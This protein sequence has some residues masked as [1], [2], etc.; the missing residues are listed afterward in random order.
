M[1]SFDSESQFGSALWSSQKSSYFLTQETTTKILNYNVNF[2]E[3]I[4]ILPDLNLIAKSLQSMNTNQSNVGRLNSVNELASSTGS[5]G[6]HNRIRKPACASDSEM[7]LTPKVVYPMNKFSQLNPIETITT[8]T[9][10]NSLTTTTTTT[11]TK[12]VITTPVK[13]KKSDSILLHDQI[14]PVLNSIF[15]LPV[16]QNVSRDIMNI[17]FQFSLRSILFESTLFVSVFEDV[18]FNLFNSA[19]CASKKLSIQE[20]NSIHKI[21]T[22]F[23]SK[24]NDNLKKNDMNSTNDFMSA[25]LPRSQAANR[26]SITS[27]EDLENINQY[28]MIEHVKKELKNTICL[29]L[30][31]IK[32][33]DSVNKQIIDNLN[34][35]SQSST[36][37]TSS[38][39]NNE[40]DSEAKNFQFYFKFNVAQSTSV[41]SEPSNFGMN[42]NG[43]EQEQPI[44]DSDNRFFVYGL[45]FLNNTVSGESSQASNRL[46]FF[47]FD[48]LF[49]NIKKS[50]INSSSNTYLIRKSL[51]SAQKI[52]NSSKNQNM[53]QTSTSESN[54]IAFSDTYRFYYRKGASDQLRSTN[55]SSSTTTNN[56]NTISTSNRKISNGEALNSRIYMNNNSAPVSTTPNTFRKKFFSIS[57]IL[58]FHLNNYTNYVSS[59]DSTFLYY[60]D[61]VEENCAK[62]YIE[63]V[64]HYLGIHSSSN[65]SVPRSTSLTE[66]KR[67]KFETDSIKKLLKIG[68]KLKLIDVDL[69]D[70]LKIICAHLSNHNN[71]E[72][73]DWSMTCN[74]SK[75]DSSGRQSYLEKKFNDLFLKKFNLL[76]GFNDLFIFTPN[77]YCKNMATSQD[78]QLSSIDHSFDNGNAPANHR[79]SRKRL[80][81][82]SKHKKAHKQAQSYSQVDSDNRALSAS[83]LGTLRNTARSSDSIKLLIEKELN[84]SMNKSL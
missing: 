6:L 31:D 41:Q 27:L 67:I 17:N 76:P 52:N 53:S 22:L 77:Q 9:F 45:F 73:C 34:A 26:G 82:R 19:T 56:I 12:E 8:T 4:R 65:P 37:P 75:N 59:N 20:T 58:K 16:S 60:L 80:M 40:I 33:G 35:V 54:K 66:D 69:T 21:Q 14:K 32:S 42:R 81:H 15:H 3:S 18:P 64:V 10:I 38:S 62:S 79:M 49:D 29:R 43:I 74:N 2:H 44:N 7:S 55:N 57:D 70:Y 13:K 46:V 28:L 11:E 72:T 68:R 36:I 48:C 23:F 30:N 25:P 39:T 5:T 47:M 83:L 71:S 63:S 84:E 61:M 51:F 50:M 24:I 1:Y 78:D